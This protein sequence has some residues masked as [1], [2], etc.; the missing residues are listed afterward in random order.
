[1]RPTSSFIISSFQKSGKRHL[2]LTGS[3]QTGK[4]TLLTQLIPLLSGPLPMPGI[5]TRAVP[6]QCVILEDNTTG[7]SA[8]IGRFNGAIKGFGNQMEPLEEGFLHTGV[9][10]LRHLTEANGDWV[11]IDE[12][13]YLESGCPA[14]QA[15][16][17]RLLAEKSVLAA[18]RKQDTPLL[19]ALK[20]REDVF[21]YDLDRPVTALGCI[22]MASGEGRRFGGNKLL[23]SFQGQPLIARALSATDTGLF[24]K[25]TVVTRHQEIAGLCHEAGVP[26]ILHSQPYRSDTIRIG[27]ESFGETMP[28]GCMFCPC[29]QPLL[30]KA[31]V[32][33][34]ARAFL[35]RPD[36]VCRLSWQGAP[37]LPIVFPRSYFEALKQLPKGKG[38]SYLIRSSDPEVHFVEAASALELRDVDTAEDLKL[39]EKSCTAP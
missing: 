7:Q 4:S 11:F 5:T 10:A 17:E 20:G 38:G 9:P 15:A 28:D 8:V 35:E 34:L 6:G 12:I 21:V 1:M 2:F 32:E 22:L 25:R 31:T 39:L 36:A 37:G 23:A 24:S 13:G 30:T 27:L 26:V 18:L 19:E 33:A 14:Y 16:L 3:R 29:D